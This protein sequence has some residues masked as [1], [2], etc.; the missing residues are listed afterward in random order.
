MK[1]LKECAG[2]LGII[3]GILTAVWFFTEPKV[4]EFVITTVK[5]QNYA[6]QSAVVGLSGKIKDQSEV[7]KETNRQL[8]IANERSIRT[9]ATQKSLLGAIQEL[10]RT[11]RQRRE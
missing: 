1:T 3:T 4:R 5:A 8:Q 11:M 9:E 7:Q 6:T 10:N 2:I